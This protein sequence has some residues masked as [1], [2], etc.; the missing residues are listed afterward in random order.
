MTDEFDIGD[1]RKPESLDQLIDGLTPEIYQRLKTAIELGK[2]EDGSR[3]SSGQLESSIQAII[4]YESKNIA[5]EQRTGV[6]LSAACGS[7]K[8]GEDDQPQ[9]LILT[10]INKDI[11]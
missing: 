9:P 7:K 10:A 4:L 6:D 3:L 8:G 1:L 2:W 5:P 11:H